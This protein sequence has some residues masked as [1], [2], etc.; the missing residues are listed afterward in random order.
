MSSNRWIRAIAPWDAPPDG[1]P[2]RQQGAG[3]VEYK[4]PG[5]GGSIYVVARRCR[6]PRPLAERKQWPRC[7]PF[8]QCIRCGHEIRTNSDHRFFD[9]AVPKM[10]ATDGQ[11]VWRRV[12]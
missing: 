9:A 6:C 4:D 8:L 12:Y 10:T 5:H 7:W 2:T 1:L 3:S 11:D